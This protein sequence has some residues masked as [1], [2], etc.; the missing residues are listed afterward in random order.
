MINDFYQEH[1]E[2]VKQKS[3]SLL[4]NPGTCYLKI[5]QFYQ[6]EK[7]IS[8]GKNT[9]EKWEKFMPKYF[10]ENIEMNVKVYDKENLFYDISK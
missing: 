6:D 2:I 7:N 9:M 1:N 8:E 10:T 5:M 4:Y 3:S